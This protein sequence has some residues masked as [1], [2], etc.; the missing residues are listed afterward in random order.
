MQLLICP[1]YHSSDLT[2]SFLGA[3]LGEITPERLWIRPI[4]TSPGALPWLFTSPQGPQLDRRLQIIAFSAGGVAAYPLMLAWQGMG[5]TGCLIAVDGWGMPLWGDLT[6]YRL[7]HDRWTHD[8]TYFPS[9]SESR[10]YFYC[11][12]GVDH[13][14]LWH[15]PQLSRGMGSIGMAPSTMTALDFICAVLRTQAD[16]S[17]AVL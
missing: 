2:H 16:S 3:L 7:S 14:S 15:S 8:T 4:W 6:I 9:A 10:G 1:G 12:P 5:G 17:N 13:L 11:H